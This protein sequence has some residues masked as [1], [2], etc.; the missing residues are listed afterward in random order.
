M[1]P[2]GYSRQH[3]PVC[4]WKGLALKRIAIDLAAFSSPDMARL[5]DGFGRWLIDEVGPQKAALTIHRYLAFFIEVERQWQ[6]VPDYGTLLAHFGAT[7]LRRVLMP[8]RWLQRSGLIVVDAQAREEDS[9]RRRIEA[10]LGRFQ[11][12]SQAAK[13]L[14]EYHARLVEGSASTRAVRLALTPAAA[15]L[16]IAEQRQQMPPNQAV[17]DAYLAQKPGQRAALYG[18]MVFLRD[19]YGMELVMPRPSA[20]RSRQRR[21]ARLRSEIMALMKEPEQGVSFRRRW[22]SLCLA[23]FHGLSRR[24]GRQVPDADIT[25]EGSGWAVSWQGR[26]YWIPS[27]DEPLE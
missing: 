7:A 1:M 6:T 25:P 3:C 12:T 19:L 16:K 5:F 17:I 27:V 13:L 26:I 9:E 24:V 4:Y 8:M 21:H 20:N 14:A 2:A 15:V 22:L 23:Y 10:T 11:P 18:F